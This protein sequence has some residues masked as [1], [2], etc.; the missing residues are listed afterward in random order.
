MDVNLY[1]LVLTA[2]PNR[3]EHLCSLCQYVS[4]FLNRSLSK[5]TGVKYREQ[6]FAIFPRILQ[7][8]RVGEKCH[9]DRSCLSPSPRVSK[10]SNV[11]SKTSSGR[12]LWE[13]WTI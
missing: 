7:G 6:F 8:R 2:T 11:E 10:Q 1:P 9:F 5:A 13:G 4:S 3:T 12:I